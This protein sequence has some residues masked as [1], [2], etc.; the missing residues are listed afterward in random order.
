MSENLSKMAI[1]LAD[2]ENELVRRRSELQSDAG[3]PSEEFADIFD[4]YD[5]DDD[6]S[7]DEDDDSDED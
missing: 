1:A 3:E 6:S 5:D 7:F 2:V 4:N